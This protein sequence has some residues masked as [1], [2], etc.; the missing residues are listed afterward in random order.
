MSNSLKTWS[1][2]GF[3]CWGWRKFG[4]GLKL[5]LNFLKTQTRLKPRSNFFL[6]TSWPIDHALCNSNLLETQVKLFSW[7]LLG[8]LICIFCN[9]NLLETQVKLFL[10]VGSFKLW[11]QLE[12]MGEQSFKEVLTWFL[13][14]AGEL[15]NILKLVWHLI[16]TL[17][18][19]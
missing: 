14:F 19:V 17:N 4:S 18:Q 15:E 11:V 8:L 16:E 13:C 1:L 10:V 7:N 3:W 9:S 5:L 6:K 12:H 2:G